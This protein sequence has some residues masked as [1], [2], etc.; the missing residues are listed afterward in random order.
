MWVR[1]QEF[2]MVFH[3]LHL[4]ELSSSLQ[5]TLLL[6]KIYLVCIVWLLLYGIFISN[7]C[8]DHIM[9][10]R[11]LLTLFFIENKT[12]PTHKHHNWI[13]SLLKWLCVSSSLLH[14]ITIH[15][16]ASMTWP[17]FMYF[18]K[19]AL[20][21]CKVRIKLLGLTFKGKQSIFPHHQPLHCLVL[22]FRSNYEA[23]CHSISTGTIDLHVDSARITGSCAS[24]HVTLVV[25]VALH[26]PSVRSS[27]CKHVMSCIHVG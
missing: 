19:H 18:I 23:Y 10:Q 20:E 4:T 14:Y 13:L 21:F 22:I 17:Y 9:I 5:I 7:I 1:H 24:S 15:V 25:P 6:Q 8:N 26:I 12:K 27:E 2:V 3:V 16:F 11:L